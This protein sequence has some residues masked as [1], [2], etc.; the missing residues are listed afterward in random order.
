MKCHL[1]NTCERKYLCC[2]Y[3]ADKKCTVRCNDEVVGCKWFADEQ[4]DVGNETELKTAPKRK[5]GKR[6]KPAI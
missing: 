5:V 6:R 1:R 4:C 2:H 3:C